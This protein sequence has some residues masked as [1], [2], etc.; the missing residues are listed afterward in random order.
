[1]FA[2]RMNDV[3]AAAFAPVPATKPVPDSWADV[4][5]EIGRT[6]SVPI[7]MRIGERRCLLRLKLED[8]NPFGSI[9]DRTAYSLILAAERE[10]A[11]GSPFT[12]VESTSGNL[13]AALA[14]MC[15]LRGHAMIAVVD[16]KTSLRNLELMERYGARI[17][18]VDRPDATGCYLG[19]RLARVKE[20]CAAEDVYW[21]DQYANPANPDIHFRLTGPEIVDD[22]G[23]D[24]D[25]LFVA[26][27][28][29]GTLAGIAR[30]LRS[31]RLRPATRLVAVDAVGS[32]ALSG[33][34]APRQLT[35]Y[36]AAHPSRFVNAADVDGT[37]WVA[38]ADTVAICRRL[39]TETGLCLGGSSGAVV[40]ASVR[41][42]NENPHLGRPVCL[43]PD[44]GVKYF[45]SIYDDS[46]VRAR[47]IDVDRAVARY[48]AMGLRFS[49]LS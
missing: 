19:A 16:P 24:M 6:P 35:G 39:T 3:T 9:K 40:A 22:V 28:T 30:Y 18:M 20:I 46:W 15:R 43:C 5:G 29:G 34:P 4:V 27:S 36:G 26:V 21:T 38:D 45:E 8:R 7:E 33:A 47:G 12:I 25:C 44:G 17:D 23:G 32:V 37:E 49:P 10:H 13:G 1:M 48:D 42:L 14:A 31:R 2:E 11:A 41:Y